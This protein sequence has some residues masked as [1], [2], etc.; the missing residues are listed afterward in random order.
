MQFLSNSKR[1]LFGLSAVAVVGALP[2][3]SSPVRA[4]LV[5]VTESIVEAVFQPRVELSLTAE[6]QVV[7]LDAAGQEK[8][9]WEN[10]GAKAQV[11]PGDV[12]R[13]TVDGSN[14]GDVE[15]S[16]LNITQPIPVQMTYVLDSA[17][18]SN[19]AL[20]TY[21]IN[22]GATFVEEPMVE[23]TLPDGTVELQPAPAE[24]YTHV[25]W[26]FADSLASAAD[27]EVGYEA[28]VK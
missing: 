27:V 19:D 3:A 24:A 6:K 5:E 25:N 26:S 17:M 9:T 23:V 20:I 18:G 7:E 11:K 1:F 28:I 14:S 15:A 21:S 8:I 2:L 16:N 10:L 12:L 4:Q 22:G 13:Y